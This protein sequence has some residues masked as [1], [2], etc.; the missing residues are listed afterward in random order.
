VAKCDGN[1]QRPAPEQSTLPAARRRPIVPIA[2]AVLVVAG[3][4]TAALWPRPPALRTG[5]TVVLADFDNRTRD[6][7]FDKTL[8]SVLRIDLGQSPF[9][10]VQPA[11]ATQD[12][13]V[14]MTRPKDMRVTTDL[15]QEICVRTNADAV[16]AGA[17]DAIGDQYIVTLTATDC[18][19]QH[20]LAQEKVEVHGREAVVPA[21]DRLIEGIRR[22]LGEPIASVSRFDI[23]LVP[24]RTASLEALRAYS[25]GLW[26]NDHGRLAEA[27]PAFKQAVALDP[28]FAAA[29]AALGVVYASMDAV[30][31]GDEATAKAYA[32]RGSLNAREGLRVEMLYNLIARHDVLAAIPVLQRWTAVYPSDAKAWSNLANAEVVIGRYEQARQDA[33]RSLT[34]HPTFEAAFVVAAR[35]DLGAGRPGLA[36][37][38]GAM[39]WSQGVADESIHREM[40]EAAIMRHDSAALQREARWAHAHPGMHVLV[41]EAELAYSVGHVKFGDEIFDKLLA[42]ARQQGL[43]S[44]IGPTQ[45]RWLADLGFDERARQ[46]LATVADPTDRDYVYTL[47]ELGDPGRAEHLLNANLA[48]HPTGTLVV[49]LSAPETRA[50]LA[51]RRHDPAAA[52]RAMQPALPFAPAN[53]DIDYTLGMGC[54]AAHDGIGAHRAFATIL[55]HP[56]WRASSPLNALAQLGLARALVIERD[57]PAARTAYARFLA[58][59]QDADADIPVLQAARREAAALG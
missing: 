12:A 52:I 8:G 31:L 24:A 25:Q 53:P 50:A 1:L 36:E 56:G 23:P 55:A 10:T 19:G 7:I 49:Y 2:A 22:K 42:L 5:N 57:L 33:D 30:A 51:L 32:L 45:A 27:V 20:V 39:T 58:R 14:L 4:A 16:L 15:A 54:L 28:A 6:P 38:I 43:S 46:L 26:L 44:T 17:L 35:A 11:K 29:W 18:S 21:L 3:L 47:A 13:L 9:V 48:A 40:I 59:W 34:L 41:A 37:A